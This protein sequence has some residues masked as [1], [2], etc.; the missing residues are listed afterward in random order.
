MQQG[1]DTNPT[2]KTWAFA[3]AIAVGLAA[4]VVVAV[5]LTERPQVR[6]TD[7]P[8]FAG[9]Q[10]SGS[11]AVPEISL[12]WV[13][14]SFG[15]LQITF[16]AAMLAL[17][18]RGRRG[19]RGLKGP[20]IAASVVYLAIWSALILAYHGQSNADGTSLFLGFPT[21]TA[22]M[23]FAL[24]PFP[25]TFT[26]YYVVGFDRW[27]ATPEDLA[28]LERTLDRLRERPETQGDEERR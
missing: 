9:M 8:E 12:L 23:L 17:G 7:H 14:W 6:S 19:L 5:A 28:E 11:N 24:W 3:F 4:T 13:G 21:P 10:Q 1:K 2:M 15:A 26:V 25:L 18:A 27:I 16:F 22:W 20:L